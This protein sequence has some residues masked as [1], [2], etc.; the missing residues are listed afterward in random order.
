MVQM[1]DEQNNQE[2][3]ISARDWNKTLA[4]ALK[5]SHIGFII[6]ASAVGGWLVGAWLDKRYGTDH[7][8]IICILV[9][10]AV[11]FYDLIRTVMRMSKEK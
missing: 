8:G 3:N 2:Q 10:V 1:A 7:W 6:P 11:G 4:T 9:F 5:Y